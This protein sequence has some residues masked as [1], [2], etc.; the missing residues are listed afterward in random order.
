V[1][2]PRIV[3]VWCVVEMVRQSLT[4]RGGKRKGLKV[5]NDELTADVRGLG[6]AD[7]GGRS[8]HVRA[9]E[10]INSEYLTVDIR[11][12]YSTRTETFLLLDPFYT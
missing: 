4:A 2:R 3:P 10:Q 9:L 12:L 1:A 5:E 11:K 7:L 8:P 6:L